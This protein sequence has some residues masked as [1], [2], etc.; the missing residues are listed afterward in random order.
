MSSVV[1]A[2]QVA[3]RPVGLLGSVAARAEFSLPAVT[4]GMDFPR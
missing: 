4:V 1:F 3:S 2:S